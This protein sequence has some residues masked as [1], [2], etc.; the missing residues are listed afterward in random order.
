[1]GYCLDKAGFDQV[2]QELSREYTVYAPKVFKDGGSFS[3]TDR[4]RYG[5]IQT[6]DEVVFDRKAE[7]SWKEVLLPL[8]QTLF[9]FTEDHIKEADLPKKGAVILLRSC[10]LQ[11][12]KRL[13]A[14]YLE[15]GGRD[16]YYQQLRDRV[17]FLLIGCRH[18]FDNCFCVDMGT[19]RSDTYDA[20]LELKDGRVYVDNRT[21]AWEATFAARSLEAA[22]VTPAY[23]TENTKHVQLPDQLTPAILYSTIW[24]EYDSRCINC[25][26][27]NFVCPTCTCFTMQDIFYTDNGKVGER[28]RVWASCMVDGFTD[29]AGG[30]SYRQKNGQRMRFKVLHKV[31]DYKKRNGYPMCVGCG[32][33]D[34]ICPE[35]I[36]FTAAV[37]KLTAACKEVSGN[38]G[39]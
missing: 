22:A 18:S 23:V 12:V 26:R 32:R 1:M 19:N 16:Y 38:A 3:D 20:Y 28:R 21:A 24:D 7:F 39:K 15:N 13:D 36:S 17:K 14:I 35:Y 37:N 5:E 10:D 4:I 33:C 8:S 6:I 30:G 2:L 9:F 27:C 31:Y 29:V 25:G 34:D 11:A